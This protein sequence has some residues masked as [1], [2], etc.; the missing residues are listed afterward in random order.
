MAA[1]TGYSKNSFTNSFSMINFSFVQSQNVETTPITK[2]A[3]QDKNLFG[4]G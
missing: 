2:F 4:E 1:R 3:L